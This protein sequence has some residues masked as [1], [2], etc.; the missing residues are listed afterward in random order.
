[1]GAAYAM[2][3]D[4]REEAAIAD[5]QAQIRAARAAGQRVPHPDQFKFA[6]GSLADREFS[7]RQKAQE[8][9]RSYKPPMSEGGGLRKLFG[10]KQG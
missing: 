7:N 10:R 8:Y 1:M 2:E 3:V 9:A 5:A 4:Q 6:P